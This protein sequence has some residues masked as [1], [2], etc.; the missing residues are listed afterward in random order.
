MKRFFAA[1]VLSTAVMASLPVPLVAQGRPQPPAAPQ[2]PAPAPSNYSID[3]P[4][5][6]AEA[7]RERFKTVMQRYPRSVG[8]V[9]RLDPT[10]FHDATYMAS[11]PDIAQFI[12]RYPQITRNPDYYLYEYG[13]YYESSTRDPRDRSMDMMENVLGGM[14]GLIVFAVV[15]CLLVWIV[16]SIVDH[17]RW[18]RVSKIQTEAHSKLLDRFSSSD[19]L[20]AYIKTPAGARFLESAP[21][22]T[23]SATGQRAVSAPLNRILW[24]VQAGLVLLFAGVAVVYARHQVTQEEVKQLFFMIGMV[25]AALGV[26][27]VLSALASYALSKRLGLLDGTAGTA[28]SS[29]PPPRF[30]STGA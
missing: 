5:L 14:A 6:D 28:A 19:E 12:G 27:F 25:T 2:A 4:G 20:L 8:R 15:T 3:D 18:L 11:Y 24:S 17:R 21:L 10:L 29:T 26:G 30:D 16:R 13:T 22:S 1:L 9:L 7:L 23:E